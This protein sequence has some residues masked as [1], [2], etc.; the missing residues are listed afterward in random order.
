MCGR[1][2]SVYQLK[3]SYGSHHSRSIWCAKCGKAKAL[4]REPPFTPVAEI[5]CHY[6]HLFGI[7][8]NIGL[9]PIQIDTEANFIPERRSFS[10]KVKEKLLLKCAGICGGC[11]DTFRQPGN[12]EIDHIITL[13]KGGSNDFGNLQLLCRSCNTQKGTGTMDELILNLKK[14]GIR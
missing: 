4:P 13:R 3:Y 7:P 9:L 6:P 8:T 2:S 1:C 11:L 14:K 5:Q 10:P 12:M